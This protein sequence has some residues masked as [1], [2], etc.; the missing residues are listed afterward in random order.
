[1]TADISAPG[2][3]FVFGQADLVDRV[4]VV[5]LFRLRE[6]HYGRPVSQARTLNRLLREAVHELGH[7]YGLH[8]CPDSSC[9]MFFSN[10]LADTDR[11]SSNFCARCRAQLLRLTVR[12]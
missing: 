4:A 10:R 7:T 6:E 1:M 11:K 3:N 5:S 8:H 2:L 9:V 12:R